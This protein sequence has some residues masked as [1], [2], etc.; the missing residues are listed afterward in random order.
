MDRRGYD[1]LVKCSHESC[2]EVDRYRYNSKSDMDKHFECNPKSDHKCFRHSKPNLVLS[3][4][5]RATVDVVMNF[6]TDDGNFWGKEKP[7][8]K[9][10]FGPGFRAFADDFPAGTK[11]KVTAQLSIPGDIEK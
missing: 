9:V 10:V 8:T 3:V 6:K 4:S 1:V 2:T 7:L 5:K 11:I